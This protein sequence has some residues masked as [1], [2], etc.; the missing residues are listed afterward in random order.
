[1]KNSNVKLK[2]KYFNNVTTGFFLYATLYK[3]HHPEIP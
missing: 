3:Q 1:M 2:H